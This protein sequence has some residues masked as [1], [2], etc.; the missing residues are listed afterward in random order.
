MFMVL[1]S[2]PEGH[3]FKSS[4]LLCAL[5]CLLTFSTPQRHWIMTEPVLWVYL[6]NR[7]ENVKKTIELSC[8]FILY[9]SYILQMLIYTQN[10]LKMVPTLYLLW[11]HIFS[12]I[13]DM[14]V[15]IRLRNPGYLVMTKHWPWTTFRKT[16]QSII[17]AA[18][19]SNLQQ[20]S[21]SSQR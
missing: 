9:T 4:W 21:L 19:N 17:A 3:L 2:W 12:F 11:L 13:T 8:A 7:L 14:N 16:I 5:N 6:P 10:A 1:V 18:V 20:H 15:V